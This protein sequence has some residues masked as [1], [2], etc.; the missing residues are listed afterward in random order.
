MPISEKDKLL[1]KAF[2]DGYLEEVGIDPADL[3]PGLKFNQG[4]ILSG[5]PFFGD[6]PDD[7]GPS[8]RTDGVEGDNHSTPSEFI[9]GGR[10][11]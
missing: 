9:P 3:Q 6:S 10:S 2:V 5:M 8:L 1:K 7:S 11:A 4:R